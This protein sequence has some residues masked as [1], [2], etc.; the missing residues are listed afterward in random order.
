M[1]HLAGGRSERVAQH[2]VRLEEH[3]AAEQRASG[4]AIFAGTA[5]AAATTVSVRRPG[6]HLRP[7]A[8]IGRPRRT[9]RSVARATRS[10]PSPIRGPRRA[11]AARPG[12]RASRKPAVVHRGD[13]DE[14]H[15]GQPQRH[16]PGGGLLADEQ[17][18]QVGRDRERQPALGEYEE[19]EHTG[20]AAARD[21]G[22]ARRRRR[23]HQFRP[24]RGRR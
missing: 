7:I 2:E 5:D 19:A 13:D 8:S 22:R 10:G 15:R 1:E 16:C 23:S 17:H 20:H 4:S 9:T 21:R 12:P 14:R 24:S 18:E 3:G 11:R 6:V